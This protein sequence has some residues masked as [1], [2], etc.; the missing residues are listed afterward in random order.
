MNF[1]CLPAPCILAYR[2]NNN[3]H[4]TIDKIILQFKFMLDIWYFSK[5]LFSEEKNVCSFKRSRGFEYGL[6]NFV[7]K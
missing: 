7:K 6:H 4:F 5:R 2:L 1:P 3:N